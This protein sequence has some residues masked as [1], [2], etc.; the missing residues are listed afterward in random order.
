MNIFHARQ[1]QKNGVKYSYTKEIVITTKP[2]QGSYN[3]TK[4]NE[5]Q[6]TIN[7]PISSV[8]NSNQKN[9]NN[10]LTEA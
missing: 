10:K 7:S 2:Q 3:S 5:H 9:S 6:T 4:N 8:V 1:A